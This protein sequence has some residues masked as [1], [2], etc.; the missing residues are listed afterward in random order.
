MFCTKCGSP[1]DDDARFC[2]SCGAEREGCASDVAADRWGSESSTCSPRARGFGGV[3]PASFA[4]RSNGR[5]DARPASGSRTGKGAAA[6][7][8]VCIAVLAVI[9]GVFVAP[10]VSNVDDSGDVSGSTEVMGE[11]PAEA[12]DGEEDVR[13]KS[14]KSV[15][16]G[17]SGFASS[18]G[19]KG[20]SA[21]K[22]EAARSD[23]QSEG[24]ILPDSDSRYYTES[25]L[26]ALSLEELYYARNE[27]YARH[28]RGF[29]NA[30][31][32]AYFRGK[33][34]YVQRYEPEEFDA[35]ASPLNE[36]EKKNADLMLQI[37][38]QR[39]SSYLN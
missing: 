4:R 18:Q 8:V 3:A 10:A 12:S 11:L 26:G 13:S 1:L 9:V 33:S 16:S 29:K 2:T 19:S 36:Y 7:A 28:G 23:S 21:Q 24:Y 17:S 37:E 15:K 31:L 5:V 20:D 32:A 39:D 22:S 30:D 27:I 35:M 6:I 25:E 34:W 38:Q 14:D